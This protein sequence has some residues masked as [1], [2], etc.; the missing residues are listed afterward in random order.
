M[1]FELNLDGNEVQ[2]VVLESIQGSGR[3]MNEN[4]GIDEVFRV[5][6]WQR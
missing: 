6:L 5:I 4:K 1:T 2:H 3:D